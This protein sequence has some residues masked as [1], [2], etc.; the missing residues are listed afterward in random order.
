MENGEVICTVW[1]LWLKR[2]GLVGRDWKC[3]IVGKYD[4][5]GK[6]EQVSL[7]TWIPLH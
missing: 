6:P 4:Y 3:I 7:V 1:P 5:S 2:G